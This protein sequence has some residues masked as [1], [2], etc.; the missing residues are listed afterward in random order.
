MLK[1]DQIA[2][3]LNER[4][5]PI[6]ESQHCYVSSAGRLY[7]DR[8]VTAS[9][10][11][12]PAK[13]ISGPK[14]SIKGYKRVNLRNKTYFLH[15]LVAK[16]FVPNPENKEQVNH[17]DGN[18]ENNCADNLEWC[19]NQENR[20]HAVRNGLHVWGEDVGNA[21]LTRQQVNEIREQCRLGRSQRSV[22]TEYG[23][24]QQ[25]VSQIISKKRWVRA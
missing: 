14:L 22:A 12:C 6:E 19:T 1:T 24:C 4:W 5:L 3:D 15:R 23:I 17:I 18:K 10:R 11:I 8:Y 7:R 20:D 2:L 16:Y 13:L 21:K 25:S 9:G